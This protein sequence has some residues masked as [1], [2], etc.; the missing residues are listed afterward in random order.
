VR[1]LNDAPALTLARVAVRYGSFNA[2]TDVSFTV[3]R[4]ELVAVVGPNGAGKSTL[5]KAITGSVRHSG[6]VAF[7]EEVCHHRRGRTHAAFIPQRSDVNLDFPIL[8]HE[9]VMLGRRRFL[10]LGQRPRARD[11]EAVHR[12]LELVGLHDKRQRPLGSLSGGQIQRVFIA[13]AL[14]QEA[15]VFLLDESLSGVDTPT[16]EMLLG[17]FT[18]L[19][20]SGASLLVS[21][22]DLSLARR[23]FR[24]CLAVNRRLV[25]DG[26]PEQCLT[27][28]RL[29]VVYGASQ[30][31]VA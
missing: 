27:G 18:D 16:T 4:G 11:R 20:E 17:L 2:L 29:D 30:E 13:R 26:D 3:G 23:R 25:A 5:F 10:R 7:G 14:A 8:V 28:D 12:A 1:V 21:T 19:A 15:D 9:V 31:D 24:R 22:H 6:D